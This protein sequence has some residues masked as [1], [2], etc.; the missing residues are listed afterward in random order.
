MQSVFRLKYFFYILVLYKTFRILK[1]PIST[2]HVNLFFYLV[3]FLP[4]TIVSSN[5]TNSVFIRIFPLN[6]RQLEINKSVYIYTCVGVYVGESGCTYKNKEF[7]FFF[8]E[9]Q[10]YHF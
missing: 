4:S 1:C 7:D 8:K 3:L 5:Y 9:V 6:Y 2:F 10:I